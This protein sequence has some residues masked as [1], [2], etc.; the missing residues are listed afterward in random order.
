MQ[1]LDRC[2][3]LS[4]QCFTALIPLLILVSTLAPAGAEDIV[5]RTLITKFGL[6]G[7]AAD[8]VEQLFT[9]PAGATS[10]LSVFSAF[11]LVISGVSFT[12]RIQKMYRA[13]WD[14]PAA[15]VR[16]SLFAALGLL[17]LLAEIMVLYGVRSLVRKLPWDWLWMLPISATAGLVLWTSI[18]YLLLNRRVHW[19]R[20][21]VGGGV[22]G[23]RYG[24]LRGGDDDLH[25]ADWS[26]STP[27]S[28]GCSGSPSRMIGWLLVGLRRARR[29]RGHR[30]RV[31]RVA[32][33]LG[34]GAQD[35]VQPVRPGGRAR[36][37]ST[38]RRRRRAST[39]ATC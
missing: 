39:A 15:G 10:G 8:A 13:A 35:E 9:T 6:E 2:I 14:E 33:A 11:L 37:R 5:A 18:P 24:G 34:G 12:R 25:A 28:S 22:S 29:E 17:A 1:G 31:R 21:L 32:R 30:R 27:T 7:S 16:S 36:R 26:R 20:L 3:V 38:S 4:S 19:R 23:C